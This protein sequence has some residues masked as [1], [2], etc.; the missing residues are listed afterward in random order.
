M[1]TDSQPSSRDRVLAALRGNPDG[2]FGQ[3]ARYYVSRVVAGA[4]AGFFVVALSTSAG[5]GQHTSLDLDFYYWGAAIGALVALVLVTLPRL[6][7]PKDWPTPE[8]FRRGAEPRDGD[9]S[10]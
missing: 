3:R 1:S 6:I 7:R 8:E 9:K 5:G 10:R 2:S 4:V